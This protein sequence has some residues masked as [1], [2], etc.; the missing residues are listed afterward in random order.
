[1]GIIAVVGGGVIG[2]SVA[3]ALRRRGGDVAVL[4]SG[5]PKR[6]ASFG[7][8]GWIVPALAA[9]VPAPGVVGTSLRWMVRPDSPLL[10]RPRADLDF[11]RW[12]LAFRRRCN[13]RDF[14]AGLDAVALFGAGT[15]ALFDRLRSEG[16]EFEE[17]RDGLL[18]VYRSASELERD[19]DR[20]SL[21]RPWGYEMP[22]LLNPGELRKLE[23]ALSPNLAGGYLLERE[24]H[25]RPDTLVHGLL[26]HLTE[27]GVAVRAG[28]RVVGFD[29]DRGTVRRIRFAVLS[30]RDGDDREEEQRVDAVVVCA[31]VWTK[32]V[33]R[34][35]GVSLPI[36]AGKGY[37]LDYEPPPIAER[38]RRPIY[39]H[40]ARVAVS[41]FAGSV[42]L[43]GTMEFS[44]L[45]ER[46]EQRRTA[47]VARAGMRYL[48]G[49]PSAVG[50]ASSVWAGFRPM[51]PDG[52]PV[53]GRL[54]GISNLFVATGHAMLGVT[55]APATGE[56]IADLV[57]GG[58]FSDKLLPF[59]PGRFDRRR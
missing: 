38:I 11:A 32:E 48:T 44:G 20:L 18:F 6:A 15:M 23:P 39:L 22:P 49:W 9:P 40:E 10:V 7:N 4:D 57:E 31:G 14:R 17:R 33:V 2:L 27:C 21:L 5:P 28:T 3:A 16:V 58:N 59:D 34:S 45:N 30:S 26:A 24:R 56:A 13:E 35:A 37:S 19:H 29:I 54:P 12:L 46:V 53:I 51:T 41:P 52:L 55:L 8:A 42:R 1:M 25:V 50:A 47:A 36:E 43:A